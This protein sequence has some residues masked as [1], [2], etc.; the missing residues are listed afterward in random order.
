MTLKVGLAVVMTVGL[1]VGLAAPQALALNVPIGSGLPGAGPA[2]PNDTYYGLQWNLAQVHAP[3]AWKVTKGHGIDIGLV[4]TGVDLSH[5]DLAGKIVASTDCTSAGGDPSKCHGTGQDDNGHGTHVAGIAAASTDNGIGVAGMAPEAGLVVAKALD[6]NGTGNFANVNA[7]IIWVVNH[8][9]RVVNL[10]L[11]IQGGTPSAKDPGPQSIA[12][13]IEYAWRHGAV[14]VLAAG[15][16]ARGHPVTTASSYQG[17]DAIVVGATGRDG[18][19]ASYSSPLA[20]AKWAVVAPGGSGY[21]TK[22]APYCGAGREQTNCV[23]STYLGP[24]QDGAYAWDEGTS[25][26]APVVSGTVALLLSLGETPAQ[27]VRAILDS[28]QGGVACGYGC[29]GR[30]DA[31]AAL[32]AGVRA[33]SIPGPL[34]GGI[35][36][37]GSTNPGRSGIPPSNP[38]AGSPSPSPGRSGSGT[39]APSAG[40]GGLTPAL[41]APPVHG[42]EPATLAFDPSRGAS[43]QA[44][45]WVGALVTLALLAMAVMT[46][47]G[48]RGAP[49]PHSGTGGRPEPGA[50]FDSSAG[51]D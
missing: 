9:A 39:P 45:I 43:R 11:G 51:D 18:Q 2:Y 14:P 35:S 36:S 40:S 20:T 28:A 37:A 19:V 44:G 22:G 32:T 1:A 41:T 24:G 42:G 31:G 26:A 21:D 46:V 49:L 15:N 17:L 13:G 38:G 47:L 27:A 50:D 3:Q 29:A 8:G 33:A 30:I 10:S 12:P 6:H 4:D 48:R 16:T 34:P 23:I 7:A 25:M 5:P